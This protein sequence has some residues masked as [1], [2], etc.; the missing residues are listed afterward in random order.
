[1]LKKA[2]LL[3]GALYYLANPLD[4]RIGVGKGMHMSKHNSSLPFTITTDFDRFHISA[5]QDRGKWDDTTSYKTYSAGF[6]FTPLKMIPCEKSSD[7]LYRFGIGIEYDNTTINS[8]K[9]DAITPYL[10]LQSS[11]Y[12]TGYLK[13]LSIDARFKLGY[14]CI[15]K[16]DESVSFSLDVLLYSYLF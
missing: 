14:R 1:M 15:F 7:D 2:L 8:R 16:K 13:R 10:L 6:T 3:L 5:S 12:G 4:T 11:D 9:Q